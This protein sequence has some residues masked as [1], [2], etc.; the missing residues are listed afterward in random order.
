MTMSD[1]KVGTPIE[2]AYQTGYIEGYADGERRAMLR[3][4]AFLQTKMKLCIEE[5]DEEI[6]KRSKLPDAW[7][8]SSAPV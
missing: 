5:L 3:L 1:N 8:G 7:R 4:W 6:L 2:E